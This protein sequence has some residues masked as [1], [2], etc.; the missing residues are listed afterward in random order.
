LRNIL[1]TVP[2]PDLD[3]P[4]AFPLGHS[5]D[6]PYGR[7]RRLI[8]IGNP[9]GSQSPSFS[10]PVVYGDPDYSW[11]AYITANLLSRFFTTLIR[12]LS[13]DRLF[14]VLSVLG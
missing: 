11:D 8:H 10:I 3:D 13:G 7:T 5:L 2:R 4:D 6:T 14:S 9:S 12:V 1:Q